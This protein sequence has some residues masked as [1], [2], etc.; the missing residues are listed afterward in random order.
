ML[1]LQIIYSAEAIKWFFF[2]NPEEIHYTNYKIRS[3]LI[4][5]FSKKDTLRS[6]LDQR[7]V[8]NKTAK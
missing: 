4:D 5:Y 2:E 3:V 8:L 1:L 6:T 7:L